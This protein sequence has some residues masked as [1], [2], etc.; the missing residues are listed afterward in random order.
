MER[1]R[2]PRSLL[3]VDDADFDHPCV[4]AS[5][6][7]AGI[8]ATFIDEGAPLLNEEHAHL[9]FAR[10]GVLWCAVP[11]KRQMLAVAGQ[12]EIPMARG[13]AWGKARHDQQLVEWFGAV[14]DFLLT[15]DAAYADACPDANWLALCEHELAHCAHVKDGYGV[16]RF[17]REGKPVFGL[18]G[19]E[20][21]QFVSVVR[22][23]GAVAAG[24]QD[25]IDAASR[26]PEVTRAE[27]DFACGTCG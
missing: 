12:A 23:Y 7:E 15:F 26:P 13:N 10:I 4:P 25:M 27:I 24:V 16:P 3:D 9:R 20:V 11:M 22:R 6:L 8:R 19:H 17:T 14:P 1:P 5:D 2:P 21:E 18:R